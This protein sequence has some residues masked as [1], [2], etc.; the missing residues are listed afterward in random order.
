MPIA[1]LSRWTN[2]VE[3]LKLL[4]FGAALGG[5]MV[6]AFGVLSGFMQIDEADLEQRMQANARAELRGEE[7]TDHYAKHCARVVRVAKFW[8]EPGRGWKSGAVLVCVASLVVPSIALV[9][10]YA[11]LRVYHGRVFWG[12]PAFHA[13]HLAGLLGSETLLLYL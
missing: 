5:V 6:D 9:S 4:V 13:K 11:D 1:C 3:A 12:S 2:V 10:L 7:A 8:S